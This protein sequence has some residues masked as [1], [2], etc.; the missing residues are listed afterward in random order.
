MYAARYICREFRTYIEIIRPVGV[1]V[2][3]TTHVIWLPV[4]AKNAPRPLCVYSATRI[5]RVSFR[6]VYTAYVQWDYTAVTTAARM[7]YI[8]LRAR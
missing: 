7:S 6:R 8:V 5:I 2:I 3:T 1:R 4:I